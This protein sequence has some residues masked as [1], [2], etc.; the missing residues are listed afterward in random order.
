[1]LE[2]IYTKGEFLARNPTWHVEDSPWKAK[3]ILRMMARNHLAPQTICEVGCGAGE[4]LKQLQERMPVDCEFWGYDISPQAIK[5][6][7]SRENEKLHFK[8]ADLTKEQ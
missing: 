1:M 7:E 8:L 2:E 4:I 5:M 6:C 3:Q